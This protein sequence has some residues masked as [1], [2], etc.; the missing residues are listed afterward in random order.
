MRLG[1]FSFQEPPACPILKLRRGYSLKRIL[2]TL[3][4]G[5]LAFTCILA[6]GAGGF[7]GYRWFSH[8][9][10]AAAEGTA[11]AGPNRDGT[12]EPPAVPQ[13]STGNAGSGDLQAP[14]VGAA[15]LP[16][17]YGQTRQSG[18]PG[19][20]PKPAEARPDASPSKLDQPARETRPA[21]QQPKETPPPGGTSP[22]RS[23]TPGDSRLSPGS[24]S[25]PA[26]QPPP[27]SSGAGQGWRMAPRQR[28][29][30]S[31]TRRS[32]SGEPRSGSDIPPAKMR[33]ARDGTF[34]LIFESR[35]DRGEMVVRL[36][37]E[38]VEKVPFQASADN[39]FRFTREVPLPPGPHHVRVRVNLPGKAA[40][41]RDWD[42]T[43]SQGQTT[44]WKVTLDRFP[45][46]L[47][48]KNIP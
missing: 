45:M 19:A 41:M 7:W 22:S 46:E 42:I 35:V 30:P 48:V 1:P 29:A 8:R 4:L 6:G 37:G 25:P 14:D 36:D 13:G 3:A 38:V 47:E 21:A 44:V 2:W 40:Q 32:A 9:R 43:V 16:Q 26:S 33:G 34:S 5:A 28:E 15:N 27:G 24:G 10:E 20:D 12:S 23:S 18:S 39:R 17:V 11:T 31:Q